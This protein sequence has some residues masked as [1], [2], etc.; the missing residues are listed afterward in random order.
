MNDSFELIST[1]L[2]PTESTSLVRGSEI[3]VTVTVRSLLPSNV[4]VRPSVSL[5]KVTAQSKSIVSSSIHEFAAKL[6]MVEHLDFKQ[7]KALGSASIVCTN[8][9]QFLRYIM[10]SLSFLTSFFFFVSPFSR[11]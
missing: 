1:S 3:K 5:T 10:C 8:P 4:M 6:H 2:D 7:D 11:K 9:K